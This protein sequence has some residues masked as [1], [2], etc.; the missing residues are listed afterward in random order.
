MTRNA[1][2]NGMS[3]PLPISAAQSRTHAPSPGSTWLLWEHSINCR[4]RRR[5]MIRMVD[6]VLTVKHGGWITGDH[7]IRLDLADQPCQ[8]APQFKCRLQGAIGIPQKKDL[9]DTEH[10]RGSALF[11]LPD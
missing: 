10:L 6:I 7:T 4:R 2:A 8:F 9:F 3:P 11:G 1:S 5:P